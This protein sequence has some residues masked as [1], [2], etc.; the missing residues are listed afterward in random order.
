MS[1]KV[2]LISTGRLLKIFIPE[3]YTPFWNA[4]RFAVGKCRSFCYLVGILWTVAFIINSSLFLTTNIIKEYMYCDGSGRMFNILSNF[5]HEVLLLIF[6]IIFLWIL[7]IALL[8][9]DIPQN[10]ILY[11]NIECAKEK[12]SI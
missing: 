3:K 4:D 12:K 9:F 11:D 8:L 6:I 1:L 5:W 10:I 7:N 2:C